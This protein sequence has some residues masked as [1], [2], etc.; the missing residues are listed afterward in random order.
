MDTAADAA[1]K[2]S[3][4]WSSR[5]SRRAVQTWWT[6]SAGRGHLQGASRAAGG[7]GGPCRGVGPPGGRICKQGL[8]CGACEQ[9]AC[10]V[11]GHVCGA[12][13]KGA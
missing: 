6:G 7:R 8:D 12:Y 10:G 4:S 13:K 3:D 2:D 9:G 1:A 5:S 11:V